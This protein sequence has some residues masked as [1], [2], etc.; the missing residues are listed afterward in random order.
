VADRLL[1][2]WTSVIEHPTHGCV[3]LLWRWEPTSRGARP[4]IEEVEPEFWTP[5]EEIESLLSYARALL[6]S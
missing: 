6:D 5:A 3:V 1:E 2:R 4:V